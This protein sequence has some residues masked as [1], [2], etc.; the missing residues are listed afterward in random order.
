MV[1]G[2]PHLVYIVKPMFAPPR[3]WR[4]MDFVFKFFI[5]GFS[6]GGFSCPIFNGDLRVG[7]ETTL[8][9][10]DPKAVRPFFV[11]ALLKVEA[12]AFLQGFI[13]S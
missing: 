10:I 5:A 6:G 12:S 9:F 4:T 3:V 1:L 13:L 11:N 8:P 2:C 7:S